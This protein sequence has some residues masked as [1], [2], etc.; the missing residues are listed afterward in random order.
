MHPL[1]TDPDNLP[2]RSSDE[3]FKPLLL[4][5]FMRA[6]LDVSSK[7]LERAY[8]DSKLP[9]APSPDTV[10]AS[11]VINFANALKTAF[12]DPV[13]PL[14]TN[15]SL[16]VDQSLFEEL[17]AE[18]MPPNDIYLDEVVDQFKRVIAALCLESQSTASDPNT[19]R[20]LIAIALRD[21]AP[22]LTL[23]VPIRRRPRQEA[24]LHSASLLPKQAPVSAGSSARD[25]QAKDQRLAEMSRQLA[26]LA[27]QLHGTQRQLVDA[28]TELGTHRD[29]RARLEDR[30]N[31][32]RLLRRH[33][34]QLEQ[35]AIPVGE[36][37]QGSSPPTPPKVSTCW[38]DVFA[39][40][41]AYAG[42]IHLTKRAIKAA[43]SSP[44]VDYSA[45]AAALTFLAEVYVPMRR[46]EPGAR[47]RCDLE[48]ARLGVTFGRTGTAA[49]SHRYRDAYFVSHGDQRLPLDLHIQGSSHRDPRYCLRIYFNYY[50]ED[51][52]DPGIAIV[53]HLPT[54][55]PSYEGS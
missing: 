43:V 42:R 9:F 55:L 45:C 14:F 44:Y 29:S 27:E 13:P 34:Y 17:L 4:S 46:G 3:D 38:E 30:T 8:K 51:E 26:A 41:E 1:M 50:Q 18:F 25:A 47:D 7:A 49:E 19:L 10:K 36:R 5:E 12:E 28:Q 11:L 22:P 16:D 6:L 33:I 40:A 35:R 15:R 53:G 31:E 39:L 48:A 23:T 20:R 21:A 54:H 32:I 52:G 37:Q 2:S 24:K